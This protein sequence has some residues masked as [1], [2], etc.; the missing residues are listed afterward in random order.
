MPSFLVGNIQAV[1]AE[2]LV[3]LQDFKAGRFQRGIVVVI[4]VIQSGHRVGQLEQPFG[5][6]EVDEARGTGDE[7]VHGLITG[8]GRS[9]EWV[10]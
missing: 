9:Q 1:E 8:H 4:Q 6:V 7:A 5:Q 10:S 2:G 3:F